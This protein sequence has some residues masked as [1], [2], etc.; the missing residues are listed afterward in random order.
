MGRRGEPRLDR[1]VVPGRIGTRDPARRHP[2]VE[3]KACAASE[4]RD[5]ALPW[6]LAPSTLAGTRSWKN[7]AKAMRGFDD[8][9]VR[10]LLAER[11]GG[12]SLLKPAEIDAVCAKFRRKDF[13]KDACVCAKGWFFDSLVFVGEGVFRVFE[14]ADDGSE[15]TKSFVEP[16]DF[17]AEMECLDKGLPAKV[18]VDAA[19]PCVALT[20][21]GADAK[22]LLREVPAWGLL[23]HVGASRAMNEM[24]SRQGFLRS[25]SASEKYRR[26]VERYPIAARAV[27]LKH[28]ASFLGITQSSLSRIRRGGW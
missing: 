18:S 22:D 17:F 10:W 16:G 24:I 15:V 23:V 20:L 28:V 21:S 6:A 9:E 5:R 26:F 3:M 27:S 11:L 12:D 2:I 8:D 13:A 25:G 14:Q 19:T 1:R 4:C 7:T